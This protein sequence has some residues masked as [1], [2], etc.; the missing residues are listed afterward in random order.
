[1]QYDTYNNALTVLIGDTYVKSILHQNVIYNIVKVPYF[2]HSSNIRI[3]S[4]Y[5][6]KYTQKK[7]NIRIK[8][9][10]YSK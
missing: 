5:D 3:S 2:K 1:M 8:E 9:K 4:R 7:K 6:Y 10:R